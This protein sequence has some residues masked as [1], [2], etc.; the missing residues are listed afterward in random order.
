MVGRY[1]HPA[2]GQIWSERHRL[3]TMVRVEI[4]RGIWP[5]CRVRRQD[6]P[7]QGAHDLNEPALVHQVSR[8]ARIKPH[9]LPFTLLRPNLQLLIHTPH[10]DTAQTPQNSACLGSQRHCHALAHSLRVGRFYADGDGSSHRG[11]Y[12]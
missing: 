5:P 3:D 6:E 12:Q 2:M 1:T 9:G 4:D 7:Q 10:P 8:G 11:P